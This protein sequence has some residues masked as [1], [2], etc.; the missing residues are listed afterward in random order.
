[1]IVTQTKELRRLTPKYCES[2]HQPTRRP[3]R[4]VEVRAAWA[5]GHAAS[6]AEA[7]M[8]KGAAD[9]PMTRMPACLPEEG[10]E[11]PMCTQRA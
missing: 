6:S 9:E 1:M 4:T 2:I 7:A 8:S 10:V 11:L 3:T 5:L